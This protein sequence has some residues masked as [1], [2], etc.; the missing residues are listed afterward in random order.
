[1]RFPEFHELVMQWQYSSTT[2]VNLRYRDTDC[3]RA[4]N[5]KRLLFDCIPTHFDPIY[6]LTVY[7]KKRDLVNLGEPDN[8]LTLSK[9]V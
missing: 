5:F 2:N 4:S 7:D 9:V 8:H 3:V 1:M 6:F